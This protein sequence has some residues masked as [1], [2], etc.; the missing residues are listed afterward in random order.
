MQEHRPKEGKNNAKI[1][2]ITQKYGFLERCC[3]KEVFLHKINTTNDCQI[4]HVKL[5]FI[6]DQTITVKDCIKKTFDEISYLHL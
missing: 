4:A 2:K 5:A 6:A 1:A 3:D